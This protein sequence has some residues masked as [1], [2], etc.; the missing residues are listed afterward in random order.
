MAQHTKI[1]TGSMMPLE[2]LLS[3]MRDPA[4][5]PA[6]RLDAAKSAAPFCHPRLSSQQIEVRQPDCYED[7][8]RQL[9]QTRE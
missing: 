6:V 5:A 3:V 8:L 1:L 2:Y 9:V 7:M 4:A